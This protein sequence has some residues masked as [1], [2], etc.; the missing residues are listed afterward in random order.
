MLLQH[1]RTGRAADTADGHTRVQGKASSHDVRS[2]CL[3]TLLNKACCRHGGC[4]MPCPVTDWHGN[5][6]RATLACHT[7]HPRA[8]TTHLLLLLDDGGSQGSSHERAQ[9]AGRTAGAIHLQRCRF[10]RCNAQQDCLLL[11]NNQG[12]HSLWLAPLSHEQIKHACYTCKSLECM[13]GVCEQVHGTSMRCNT[14][15]PAC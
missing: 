3:R 7:Q 13:E 2:A 5:S 10:C 4:A 6:C 11:W 14:A 8:C 1:A 9:G 12:L 15:P